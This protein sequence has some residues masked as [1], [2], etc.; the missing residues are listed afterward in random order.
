[1][2]DRNISLNKSPPNDYETEEKMK[3]KLRLAEARKA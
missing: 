2:T 1:M 3:E